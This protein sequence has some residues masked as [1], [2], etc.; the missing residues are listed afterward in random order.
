[1]TRDPVTSDVRDDVFARDASFTGWIGIGSICVAPFLDRWSDRCD[2]RTTL[3]HVKDQPKVGA[4][5][6]KRGPERRRRYRA[7]SDPAH[8]ASVCW[9]HHLDGWAT[10]HRPELRAY[11]GRKGSDA[12]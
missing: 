9:H 12:E 6:V 8:L 7:P 3:D 10:A 2:G 4:P 11:L 1:M 5:I